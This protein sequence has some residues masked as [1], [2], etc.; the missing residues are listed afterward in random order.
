[1][2]K[3]PQE[4]NRYNRPQSN[5]QREQSTIPTIDRPEYSS[6]NANIS[7]LNHQEVV[8]RQSI[9]NHDTFEESIVINKPLECDMDI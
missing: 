1:L 9:A 5:W 6:N 3:G 7:A 8:S 4:Y 2:R